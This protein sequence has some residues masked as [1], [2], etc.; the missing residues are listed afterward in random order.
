M[1]IQP[2]PEHFVATTTPLNL[3]QRRRL[4]L[5][6]LMAKAEREGA[7]LQFWARTAALLAVEFF[8]AVFGKWDPASGFMFSAVFVF[9]LIGLV[10]YRLV[11]KGFSPVW[12]GAVFGTLD[13]ILL[14]LLLV[15]PNPFAEIIMPPAMSLREAGF[16]YLLIFVC[17][18]ALTLSPRLAAWLGI[19]AAIC[20]TAAVVWVVTRPGTIVAL[21]KAENMRFDEHVRLYFNPNFVDLIDQLTHVVV[22]LIITGIIATVVSRSRKMADDYTTAER[23]R[24][25]LARHFSPNVVDELASN[26]E[27]FGPVRRQDVAV[28]FADI[29]GFTAYSEDHPAEQVFELLRTFH[30]R[31]EQV[32]FD[33]GGTVDNYIGDCIMATFGIPASATDDATRALGCARAMA[34]AVEEWNGERRARGSAPVD[35]RIGCQYGP[36]VLGAIGSERNLSFAVVGDTCNVASRLQTMCRELDAEVCVGAD[37][38]EAVKRA[39]DEDALSGMVEHGPIHVRGRDHE[40][41]VWLAPKSALENS[42]VLI[43]S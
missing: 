37:L 32:V 21:I 9:F 35:V 38:I 24:S 6:S 17:L 23:A 5:G 20:W 25:N 2:L 42:G 8:F 29:V 22:I 1:Q 16:Q 3:E 12:V 18:G 33:H 43:A 30:R 34:A 13:M 19:A 4:R 15:G 7:R 27:P 41:E 31:M 10:H 26:D 14:T 39:G 11:K 28:L 36:V 40:V